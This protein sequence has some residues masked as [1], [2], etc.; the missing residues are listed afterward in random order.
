MLTDDKL[1]TMLRT[2]LVTEADHVTSPPGLGASI[3][4]RHTIARRRFALTTA[5]AVV[6]AAAGLAA[7]ISTTPR[8][9]EPGIAVD[10]NPS[11]LQLAGYTFTLPQRYGAQE[12]SCEVTLPD[13]S[14]HPGVPGADG[15]CLVL[16]EE[17]FVPSWATENPPPAVADGWIGVAVNEDSDFVRLTVF[18]QDPATGRYLVLTLQQPRTEEIV[19]QIADLRGILEEGLAGGGTPSEQ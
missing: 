1:E 16:M 6:V 4:R 5:A 7:M 19:L 15:A 2:A 18:T 3:R 8:S 9:V 11:R 10:R 14:T 12:G 13:G 17:G